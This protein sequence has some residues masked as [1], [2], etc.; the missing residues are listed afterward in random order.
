ML[1]LFEYVFDGVFCFDFDTLARD[2]VLVLY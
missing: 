2:A 1:F